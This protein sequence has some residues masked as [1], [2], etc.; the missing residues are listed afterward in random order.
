MAIEIKNYEGFT[1][2][3]DGESNSFIHIDINNPK[4]FYEKIFSHFSLRPSPQRGAEEKEDR[5]DFEASEKHVGAQD[6]FS[7]VGECAV[8]AGGTDHVEAGSDVVEAGNHG[9]KCRFKIE[10]VGE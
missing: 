9:G 6:K 3:T 1:V 10:I 5:E 4:L 2:H 7:E 8:V